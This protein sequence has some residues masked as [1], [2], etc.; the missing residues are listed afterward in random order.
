MIAV[1]ATLPMMYPLRWGLDAD[2]VTASEAHCSRQFTSKA[3]HVEHPL[4]DRAFLVKASSDLFPGLCGVVFS[5]IHQGGG[6][7]FKSESF[8][9]FPSI[10]EA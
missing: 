3:S 2:V 10:E 8:K 5:W 4:S 7:G 1:A 9:S 6:Q